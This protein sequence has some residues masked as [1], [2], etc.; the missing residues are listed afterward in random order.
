[1]DTYEVVESCKNR[2]F[3]ADE[4][5]ALLKGLT[6]A[7]TMQ[8]TAG[9]NSDN[10]L[11]NNDNENGPLEY[12]SGEQEALEN[13]EDD[14][15]SRDDDDY[16]ERTPVRR[17]RLGGE[18]ASADQLLTTIFPTI[19]KRAD[20]TYVELSCSICGC[21]SIKRSETNI[22]P[23]KG[24]AGFRGHIAAQHND[25]WHEALESVDHG[26]NGV[27][28]QSATLRLSNQRELP[29][30]E[31]DSIKGNGREGYKVSYKSTLVGWKKRASAVED[32][33]SST[34][35]RTVGGGNRHGSDS[36]QQQ[37]SPG[38][39]MGPGNQHQDMY[40]R[41]SSTVLSS[42]PVRTSSTPKLAIPEATD[43]EEVCPCNVC[44]HECKV[45]SDGCSL[46]KLCLQR[47][48]GDDCH[49]LEQRGLRPTCLNYLYT[50]PC[51]DIL[52]GK[53]DFGHDRVE[54]RRRLLG[55]GHPCK[56]H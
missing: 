36:E 51:G 54:E 9:T 38:D 16:M 40:T 39:V 2:D 53:C 42:I 46:P 37:S 20:G 45:L 15:S 22:S 24:E 6:G 23:F 34:N 47:R 3:T 11:I 50:Q 32:S 35:K 30:A 26:A 8:L 14:S 52:D 10:P 21:N 25:K 12:G 27:P 56:H 28:N 1:M 13:G 29:P 48:Y 41:S 19:I 5:N 44:G 7:P 33:E 18:M 4:I 43:V 31:V 17:Q 55:P 49:P